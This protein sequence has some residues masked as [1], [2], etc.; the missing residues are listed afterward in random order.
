MAALA[1]GVIRDKVDIV[2]LR[3]E[4]DLAPSRYIEDRWFL[5]FNVT[6]ISADED[7]TVEHKYSDRVSRVAALTMHLSTSSGPLHKLS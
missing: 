2:K 1:V 3:H 4:G 7:Q 6:D 5:A